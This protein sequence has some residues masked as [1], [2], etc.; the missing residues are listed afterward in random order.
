M[1]IFSTTT[2]NPSKPAPNSGEM[3]VQIKTIVNIPNSQ[4]GGGVELS[5]IG[6]YFR[7][8]S[9]GVGAKFQFSVLQDSGET[10]ISLSPI[11]RIFL[12]NPNQSKWN[13]FIDLPTFEA[14]YKNKFILSSNIGLGIKGNLTPLFG[15]QGT[16]SLTHDLQGTEQFTAISIGIGA[17]GVF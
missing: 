2:T 4:I 9:S 17:I 5:A 1:T 14:L 3:G 13:L 12:R 16:T 7:K 8:F 15:L 6:Y 11:F 10:R